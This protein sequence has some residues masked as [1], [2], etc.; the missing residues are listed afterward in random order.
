[1]PTDPKPVITVLS[2]KST[3][4]SALIE[5]LLYVQQF[6][7]V[8][9]HIAG[10]ENFSWLSLDQAEDKDAETREDGFSIASEV[11]AAALTAWEVEQASEQDPTLAYGAVTTGQ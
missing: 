11:I 2:V 7:Y 5:R 10:K 1:M 6:H 8:V 3:P 9:K 4:S